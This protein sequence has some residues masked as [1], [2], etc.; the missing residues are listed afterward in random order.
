[1]ETVPQHFA[2]SN[3]TNGYYNG[4][5]VDLILRE[6]QTASNRGREVSNNSNLYSCQAFNDPN[7]AYKLDWRNRILEKNLMQFKVMIY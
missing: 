3:A 5:E 6:H 7:L 2:Y 1:M 4:T